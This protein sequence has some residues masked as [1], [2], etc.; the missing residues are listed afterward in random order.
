M[1]G[2][3]PSASNKFRLSEAEPEEVALVYSRGRFAFPQTNS[4]PL[5]NLAIGAV[6]LIFFDYLSKNFVSI[7]AISLFPVCAVGGVIYEKY[8]QAQRT[9]TVKLKKSDLKPMPLGARL[10]AVGNL[11]DLSNLTEFSDQPFEPIIIERHMVVSSMWWV[12]ATGLLAGLVLTALVMWL[13][14]PFSGMPG[15]MAGLG[16]GVASVLF[17][18]PARLRPLYYRI[19]PGRMDAMRYSLF[20]KKAQL[21]GRIDLSMARIRVEFAR[22]T[23]EIQSPKDGRFKMRLFNVSEPHEFVRGL[24]QAALCKHPAPP[25]PDD[26]LLG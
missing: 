8:N 5:L 17:W 24:F 22:Q 19:V 21:L 23:I 2:A 15:L 10:I 14:G 4:N 13:G 9:P 12:F 16:F 3:N 7:G 18:I 26:Q 6:I 11:D 1:I 25:L 20:Q